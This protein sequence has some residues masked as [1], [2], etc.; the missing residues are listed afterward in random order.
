MEYPQT[1]L[2][3]QHAKS[4]QI[5][6]PSHSEAMGLLP[7][8]AYLY[9]ITFNFTFNVELNSSLPFPFD[10]DNQDKQGKYL[11]EQG[12]FQL[13]LSVMS[14]QEEPANG[15]DSRRS[16]WLAGGRAAGLRLP[17]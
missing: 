3:R 6:G 16:D 7:L 2:D 15:H 1:H 4:R 5:L 14:L 17:E 11:R 12:G 13:S 10:L 9:G 8:P